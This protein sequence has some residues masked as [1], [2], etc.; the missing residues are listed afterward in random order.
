[1]THKKPAGTRGASKIDRMSTSLFVPFDVTRTFPL[2]D[3][4]E[5]RVVRKDEQ[6]LVLEPGEGRP[7][8]AFVTSQI[9]YH[10]IAQGEL[11]GVPFAVT[12]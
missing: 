9:T 5:T 1:M 11:A 2:P 10:H 4:L 7:P 6:V 8:L 3:A 12:F